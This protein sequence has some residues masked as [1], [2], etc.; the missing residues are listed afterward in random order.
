MEIVELCVVSK[1]FFVLLSNKFTLFVLHLAKEPTLI[2]DHKIHP[3]VY[4]SIVI[5]V[6]CLSFVSCVFLSLNN[7][8]YVIYLKINLQV[9]YAFKSLIHPSLHH[10]IHPSIHPFT[11]YA[12]NFLLPPRQPDRG[13]IEYNDS[14]QQ[15]ESNTSGSSFLWTRPQR[16]MT[17]APRGHL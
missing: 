16:A 13:A 6:K 4:L 10:S 12:P 14:V 1:L 3:C 2:L 8:L 9:N 11:Q 5:S 17:D 7:P 15:F